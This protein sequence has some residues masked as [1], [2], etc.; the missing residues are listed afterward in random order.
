MQQIIRMLARILERVETDR[1]ELNANMKTNQAMVHAAIEETRL[2][3]EAAKC[4]FQSQLEEV[5]ARI[6]RRRR[7]GAC[8]SAA[9]PPKF[10]GTTSWALFRRQFETV[11]EHNCW[12]PQEKS[13]YLITALQGR[14]ADV[15]HG[16]PINTT[17]EETLQTLEDRFGTNILPSHN[18]VS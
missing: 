3:I 14:A 12:A 9:Q 5:D 13:T 2:T 1:K 7:T 15:L 6:E 11:A 8:A 4:E 10:D 16:I 18:A 17:Y